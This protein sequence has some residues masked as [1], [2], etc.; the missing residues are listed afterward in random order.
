MLPVAGPFVLLDDARSG[1]GATLYRNPVEIIVAQTIDEVRPALRRIRASVADGRHAAG[2]IGY[3]AGAALEARLASLVPAPAD[4][5]L[6]WFGL[7]ARAESLSADALAAMLPGSAG[8]WAGKPRPRIARADYDAAIDRVLTLIGAGDIYQANLSFRADVR[9]VGHPLALYGRLRTSAG[10]GWGGIVH[11]GADWLLSFSPESFFRIEGR[12]IVA[13]P[14]KGTAQRGRTPQED[15]LY[16]ARLAGDP[17]ERAENLM[18]VDLI[19]NDL[20]RVAVA[21]SVRVPELFAVETYPTIQQMVS[22]VE[23]DL[24]PGRDAVDVIEALF[25]CGSITGAPK[26]RAMEII[27][28]VEAD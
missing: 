12:R 25:P 22:A 17:K 10:A 1:G 24:V 26:I 3:E 9:V 16:A 23:A 20:S 18:I 19:R 6:L 11:D 8:A 27:A 15:A 21:G 14:M 5:P 4:T 28:D 13:R 7:F 2:W